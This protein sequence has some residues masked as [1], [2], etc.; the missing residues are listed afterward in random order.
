MQALIDLARR[1]L[2]LLYFN[3]L[4]RGL[5]EHDRAAVFHRLQDLVSTEEV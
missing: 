4:W 3:W 5:P 1:K 2:H